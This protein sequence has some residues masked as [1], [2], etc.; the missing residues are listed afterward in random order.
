MYKSLNHII[1]LLIVTIFFILLFSTKIIQEYDFKIY[2]LTTLAFAIYNEDNNTNHTSNVVIVNIDNKSVNEIEQWPWS[3]VIYAQLIANINEM[4]PATIGFNMNFCYKDKSS[5]IVI[6]KFYQKY[7]DLNTTIKNIPREL[8]NNDRFL[9]Q[10]LAKSKSILSVY[11]SNSNKKTATH[12]NNLSYNILDMN[13]IKYLSSATYLKCNTQEF[14]YN[15]PHF[16][17]SNIFVDRDGKV[18]EIPLLKS[19]KHKSI[20]SF[21]LATLLSLNIHNYD[22]QKKILTFFDNSILLESR[23]KLLLP[24]SL[25]STHT[26]SA[27]DVLK[28]QVPSE[29]FHGKIVLIGSTI[30]RTNMYGQIYHG[31]KIYSSEIHA[32]YI[33]SLLN[34]TFLIQN[35]FYKKLNI[36]LTFILS[37]LLYSLF[38][39]RCYMTMFIITISIVAISIFWLI[40]KFNEGIYIS[41]GYFWFPLLIVY[42]ILLI[43]IFFSKNRKE[44]ETLK[45]NLVKSLH[46]TATSM[47]LVANTHDQETGEHLIRT[48]KYVKLLAMQLY[49]REL[50]SKSITLHKIELMSEAAPL[51]DIG[52]VGISDNILKKPGKLS[53][54]EFEIMKRHSQLGAD[55]ITQSLEYYDHN[56][57]LAVAYNIALY[58]HERW[59]GTGYPIGLKEDEIPIEAQ[60]MS[61]ADVYDALISK[62]RYKEAFTYE[63]AES[64]I[65]SERGK[66]FNPI[67]V[68]I[69]IEQKEIFKSISLEWHE[70]EITKNLI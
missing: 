54:E 33:E 32:S 61:I 14:H 53:I 42:G 8:Q 3:R 20:P 6:R 29:A 9:A 46:S 52:K 37:I 10:K 67:L 68:D 45:E 58:H 23:S 63:K 26:F 50:Y 47:V 39:K 43:A 16:G 4:T 25:S 62:R 13:E 18:R 66:A 19:Y 65:I 40:I 12:C 5:P 7:F 35:N 27:I 22:T 34:H 38:Q 48:K 69:F 51:H 24:Y 55:I 11:L 21:G 60:L 30:N 49:K 41:I 57:L 59:D 2:D 56:P 31:K 36:T 1:I 70:E 44:K 28:K 17:F 15:N 64:I